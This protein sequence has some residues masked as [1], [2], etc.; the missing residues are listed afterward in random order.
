LYDEVR[1]GNLSDVS[2]WVP[3][4]AGMSGDRSEDDT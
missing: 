2:N 4:S 3:A 1:L